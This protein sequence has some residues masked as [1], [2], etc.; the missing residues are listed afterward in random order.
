MT[1][2][3]WL[4]GHV[5]LVSIAVVHASRHAGIGRG[6]IRVLT[7]GLDHQ[8]LLL[9]TTSDVSD[10]DR[11]LYESEDGGSSARASEG[12]RDHGKAVNGAVACV[13][14]VLTGNQ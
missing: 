1:A 4:G 3:S 11:R 6:L 5:E 12:H 13:V 8:R 10:P 9:M 2:D 7:E 14:N